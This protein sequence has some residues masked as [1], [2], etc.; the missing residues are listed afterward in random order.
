MRPVVLAGDKLFPARFEVLL[1]LRQAEE[2]PQRAGGDEHAVVEVR[3]PRE[4]GH[5][6]QFVVQLLEFGLEIAQL[7]Q[8]GALFGG[9]ASLRLGLEA[10][11]VGMS[12]RRAS[13]SRNR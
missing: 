3:L 12:Q 8:F 4:L 11:D 1:P 6:E 13:V 2:L 5:A 9:A 7:L 10:V